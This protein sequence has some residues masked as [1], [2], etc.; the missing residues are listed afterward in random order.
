MET[1][2]GEKWKRAM[3][4]A[5]ETAAGTSALLPLLLY[6]ALACAMS[7]PGREC[8]AGGAGGW[9]HITPPAGD[10]SHKATAWP[11]AHEPVPIGTGQGWCSFTIGNCFGFGK[12]NQV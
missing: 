4:P 7:T 11:G 3:S 8:R 9:K 1:F 2:C 5:A 6:A 10:L 12:L